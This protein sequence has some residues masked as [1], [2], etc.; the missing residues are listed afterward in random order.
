MI[1]IHLFILRRINIGMEVSQI[2][3]RHV[4]IH[5]ATSIMPSAHKILKFNWA[6]IAV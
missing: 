2:S 6:L 5:I 4:G 3:P 1:F